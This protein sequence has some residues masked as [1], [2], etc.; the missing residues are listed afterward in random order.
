MAQSELSQLQEKRDKL[1]TQLEELDGEILELKNKRKAELLAELK[2]LGLDMPRVTAAS[3][4]SDG[5][6][7]GRPKG[8]KMSDSQKEA[9]REGR[10]RARADREASKDAAATSGSVSG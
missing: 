3:S 2:E 4:A 1:Q 7:K 9:L 6:R 5:K 10:A 8:F